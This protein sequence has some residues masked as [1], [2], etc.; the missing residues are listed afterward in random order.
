MKDIRITKSKRKTISLQIKSDG[1]T[2]VKV[3][4]QMSNTQIQDF[5][6]QKS[7]RIEKHLRT[8]QERQQQMSQIKQFI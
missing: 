2:E 3:P 4:V 8:V 6:N 7:D 1:S 5:L